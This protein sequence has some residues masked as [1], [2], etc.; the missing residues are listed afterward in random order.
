MLQKFNNFTG[1]VLLR[2]VVSFSWVNM[3]PSKI[4]VMLLD[5]D[6]DNGILESFVRSGFI[7]DI[8][9]DLVFLFAFPL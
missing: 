3:V 9:S 4:L 8:T 5:S 1:L 6:P 2:L 7:N